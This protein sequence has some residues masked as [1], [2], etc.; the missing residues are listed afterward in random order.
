MKTV[1]LIPARYRS[2]RF[3][4]KPLASLLGKPMILW[5]A[6][7]SAKAVGQENVYVATEDSRILDVV[8]SAGFQAVM[9]S[10]KALTGTDR[11]AE[12][13]EQIE[14]D[15]YINVQGDEPIV[16]PADILKILDKK[17]DNMDAVINGYCWIS[18][19]ENPESINIPKVITNEANKLVYMSRRA[20]PGFKEAKNAPTRYK[21]Q[22]CIYAFTKEEL[23]A[24]K[25]FDRKSELEQSEDIEILRYLELDKSVIMV[26]TE[27]GSLAVDIPDDIAPVE[28]ALKRVHGL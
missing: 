20:L 8:N 26:E 13:A 24:F 7:L 21:K 25:K 6:E 11:L 18:D 2:S 1:V 19:Q 27:G 9:T 16:N 5:V 4:G 22:V 3:P 17:I 28:A 15:I 23:D 14:A 12:A 10:D